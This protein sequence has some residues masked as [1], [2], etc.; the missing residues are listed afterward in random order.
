VLLIWAGIAVV[1]YVG[2]YGAFAGTDFL[3]VTR[4]EVI[5]ALVAVPLV[6]AAIFWPPSAVLFVAAL[7]SLWVLETIMVL[8][9]PLQLWPV[10]TA[11]L[12]IDVLSVWLA[13]QRAATR[14]QARARGAL[15]QLGLQAAQAPTLP[16][17]ADAI[18]EHG[19][20]LVGEGRLRLWVLDRA[21]EELRLV[22]SD[23]EA[24]IERDH[25]ARG[26]H[27]QPPSAGRRPDF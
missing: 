25:P 11:L 9:N 13:R 20:D 4:P 10:A 24:V 27:A 17:F 21:R 8:D 18:Q 2:L 19:V 16:D 26:P 15:Q 1:A 14:R 3:G 7:V 6:V 22:A 12:A 23:D 5:V